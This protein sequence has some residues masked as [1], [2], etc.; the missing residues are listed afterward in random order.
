MPI[1]GNA[2]LERVRLEVIS[3]GDECY[4]S[5]GRTEK[6]RGDAWFNSA[7]LAKIAAIRE[8]LVASEL[9]DGSEVA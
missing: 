2:T 6:W 7:G 1:R 9:L 3:L 5:A 4:L 8:S